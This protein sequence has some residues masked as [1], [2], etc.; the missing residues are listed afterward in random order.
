MKLTSL[1]LVVLLCVASGCV[2]ARLAQLQKPDGRYSPAIYAAGS[3]SFSSDRSAALRDIAA[4]SDITEGEQIYLLE[5]LQIT[6]GF[7]GDKKEVL[8]ALLN[9]RAIT[10]ATKKRLAEILPSL[11]LFSSDAKV[12]VDALAG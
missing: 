11:G 1:L 5:V 10:N 4:K 7:S 3:V 8:L 2:S 6:D 9:N 12:V